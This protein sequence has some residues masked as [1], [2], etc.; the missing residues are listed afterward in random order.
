MATQFSVCHCPALIYPAASIREKRSEHKS[1]MQ[2]PAT[3]SNLIAVFFFIIFAFGSFSNGLIVFIYLR[4]RKTMLS[5]AKDILLFSLAIGDF[6]MSF[7]ACPLGFSSAI[8][9]RWLWGHLGCVSYAFIMTWMGLASITQLAILAVERFVTLRSLTPNIVSTRRTCK[10]VIASWSLTF[11]VSCAPFIGW[12][13]YTFEGFGL[14][15]AVIWNIRSVGNLT[16]CLFLL[17]IFYVVPV[18]AIL[19]SYMKIFSI[20]RRIYK[21]A[22]TMWGSEAQATKEGYVAQVKVAKQSVFMIVGFMFAWTPYAVM[23][24]MIIFFDVK[25]SL[26][27]REYP[28]MFAKTSVIYNPIIYFFTYRIL[29]VRAMEVLKCSRNIA[30]PMSS[31]E[32]CRIR[33]QL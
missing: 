4:W 29:R 13:K 2:V 31:A 1:K 23:S 10:A 15:C 28:S 21:N 7:F 18:S 24:A 17:I 27:V 22:D 14:H 8:A 3:D 19:V 16:Y 25:I 33:P 11:L 30:D 20:V 12:S 9:R 6:M 26:R 32:P 5:H